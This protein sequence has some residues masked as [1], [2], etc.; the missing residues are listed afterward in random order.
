MACGWTWAFT[1]RYCQVYV[2]E[3]LINV[4]R[5]K[6]PLGAP[7]KPTPP[8]GEW[9]LPSPA[10]PPPG[11]CCSLGFISAPVGCLC[12]TWPLPVPPPHRQP[13]ASPGAPGWKGRDQPQVATGS[14][15]AV[16]HAAVPC[17]GWCLVSRSAPVPGRGDRFCLGSCHAW[18]R[19]TVTVRRQGRPG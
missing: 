8:W 3:F 15:A 1:Q 6:P 5:E 9:C 7:V 13:R 10:P 16:N 12:L 2:R 17:P 18:E 14:Q 11:A 19:V 4:G